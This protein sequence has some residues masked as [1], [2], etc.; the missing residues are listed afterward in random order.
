MSHIASITV[1]YETSHE[2]S[3]P[4]IISVYISNGWSLND[5]GHISLRPL[6]DKDD[7]SW[8]QLKLDQIEELYELVT[9]KVEVS[10]DPAV[11][12]MWDKTETGAVT[13]FF[14][15]EKRIDFLL[16]SERKRHSEIPDWTDFS[17]YLPLI[18]KPLEASNIG[19]SKIELMEIS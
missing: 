5:F 1:H 15:Q 7:F 12:L 16:M 10:E 9:K 3:V 18:F 2:I 6:G 14:P 4:E 13:T 11:V 19:I 17:W 8:I